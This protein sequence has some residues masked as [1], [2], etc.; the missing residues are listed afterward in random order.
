MQSWER[1]GKNVI[2][3][4]AGQDSLYKGP[5][6]SFRKQQNHMCPALVTT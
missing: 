3:L 6:S 4:I 5:T 2:D 1:S